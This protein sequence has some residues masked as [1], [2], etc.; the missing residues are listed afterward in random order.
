[1]EDMFAEADLLS[2]KQKQIIMDF[3]VGQAT[4][5]YLES[6][7]KLT[8]TLNKTIHE[9][10]SEKTE[11]ETLFEMDYSTKQWRKLKKSVVLKIPV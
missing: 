10:D 5:P 6:G 3:M 8:F 1:M 2:E 11:V 9:N 4:K 7:D